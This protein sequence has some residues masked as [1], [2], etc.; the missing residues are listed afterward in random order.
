MMPVSGQAPDPKWPRRMAGLYRMAVTDIAC[1][2]NAPR[3][4]QATC[5][6]ITHTQSVDFAHKDG[7]GHLVVHYGHKGKRFSKV[8]LLEAAMYNARIEALVPFS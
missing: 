6:N 4:K 5:Y 3:P 1:R 7:D 2:R 8:K